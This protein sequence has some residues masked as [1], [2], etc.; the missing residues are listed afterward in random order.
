M[1][2][3]STINGRS[4]FESAANEAVVK[5]NAKSC[6]N[7]IAFRLFNLV[8]RFIRCPARCLEAIFQTGDKSGNKILIISEALFRSCI[9]AFI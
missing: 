8:R 9:C 6:T 5:S 7:A 1:N 3:Q 4:R 2:V